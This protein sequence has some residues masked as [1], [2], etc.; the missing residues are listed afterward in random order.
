[1]DKQNISFAVEECTSPE[2]KTERIVQLLK[3]NLA[4][5]MIYFS[6]RQWAEKVS[7]ELRDRLKQRVAFYHGG[8]EQT[9]RMLVQQQFMNNQLDVICCTSA[10]GMGVD[11]KRH[12]DRPTLPFAPSIRILHS[13]GREGRTGRRSGC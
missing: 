1:M 9:D 13:R 8:M 6:S 2:E 10:F 11:K 12:T 3:K 7:F 5:T 4:P